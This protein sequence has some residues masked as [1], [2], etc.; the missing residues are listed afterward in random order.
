MFGSLSTDEQGFHLFNKLLNQVEASWYAQTGN[1]TFHYSL[2]QKLKE[3][4]VRF[5]NKWNIIPLS[6]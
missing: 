1:L 4:W 5:K 2:C 6:Q 3:A